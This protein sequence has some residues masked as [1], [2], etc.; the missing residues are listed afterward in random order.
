MNKGE[1]QYS[2]QLVWDGNHGNGTADYAEYGREHRL[3]IDGKPELSL[4]ADAAFRGDAAKHNPE[5]LLIAAISSCHM[6]SYLALCAKYGISVL[7][8]EDAAS[9]TMQEDGKGGGR[10]VE[11]T[12]RPK[13]TIAD[14]EQIDRAVKLHD[15]AHELCFIANSCSVPIHHQP[16]VRA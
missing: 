12:L 1:H 2:A 9:G 6:L 7:S 15:R 10:F 11:V 13:V 14:P 3:L 4:T 8:Y 5:D 16:E